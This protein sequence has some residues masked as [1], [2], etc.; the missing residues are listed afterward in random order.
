MMIIPGILSVTFR[1]HSPAYIIRLTREAGLKAIAWGSDVHVPTGDL[2]LA[3]EVG[4]LTAEA[5]L[6]V[7]EYA[8]YFRLGV[9][10]PEE[11]A[12][13]IQTAEALGTNAIRVW[14]G[15]CGSAEAGDDVWSRTFADAGVIA[16]MARTAGMLVTLEYHGNTLTDTIASTQRLMEGLDQDVWRCEWQRTLFAPEEQVRSELE[17]IMPYLHKIHV[18]YWEGRAHLPLQ[19]GR[20]AWLPLLASI[21]AESRNT[22]CYALMEFVKDSAEEQFREDA[23][24]LLEL[25]ESGA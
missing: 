14:A 24:V 4:R 1:G 10:A 13:Y 3:S 25:L 19:L 21:R 5:G 16:A 9:H 20:E 22:E 12:A 18:F 23:A 7:A 17:Q 15:S 11:F 2:L 8:S 6:Q